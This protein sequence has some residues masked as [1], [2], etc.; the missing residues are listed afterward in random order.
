MSLKSDSYMW[1]CMGYTVEPGHRWTT[2]N[3]AL[4]MG[5]LY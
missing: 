5:W 2:K 3:L 4:L 1:V